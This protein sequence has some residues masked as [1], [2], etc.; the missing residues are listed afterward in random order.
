MLTAS[1]HTGLGF[2]DFRGLRLA[3]AKVVQTVSTKSRMENS[4]ENHAA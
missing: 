4:H 3:A 2:L 1:L